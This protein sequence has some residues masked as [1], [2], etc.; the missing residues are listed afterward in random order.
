MC[1]PVSLTIGGIAASTALSLYGSQQSAK[2]ASSAARATQDANLRTEQAQNTA[3]NQRMGA[4]SRQTDAQ[5]AVMRQTMQDRFTAD[6]QMR[7]AQSRAMDLN[8]EN[9]ARENQTAESLRAQGDTQAQD[10]L[11]K[12]NAD[13]LAASEAQRAQSQNLL[14]DQNMPTTGPGPSTTDPTGGMDSQTKGALARRG[15]EAAT[16]VREYGAKV[17][18]MASYG[19]PMMDVG[20]AIAGN[21]FGIMPAETADQLLR[22]GAPTRALPGQIAFRSA[23]TEGASLD[24]LIRSRGQSGMDT[25]GLEMGNATGLANLRQGNENVL[26]GNTLGQ[27]KADAAYQQQLAGIW[28]QLGQ[29]G[30]YGAGYFGG[31]P[32]GGGGTKPGGVV[33]S[34][35]TPSIYGNVAPGYV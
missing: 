11:A 14:L 4:A 29:L 13:R 3:F 21:K 19:Q 1:D 18:K 26:A 25:A 28:G 27:A 22:A 5:T 23:G 16:N 33:G 31:S 9:L 35:G 17:A 6:Q 15:A 10:L 12:T 7:D 8:K 24:E 20:Q 32:F 30:L 2:A 34:P